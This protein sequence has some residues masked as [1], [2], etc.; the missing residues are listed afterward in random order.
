LTDDDAPGAK[1]VTKTGAVIGTPAYMSPEQLATSPGL[2][3]RTDL[4]SLGVVLFEMLSGFNPYQRAPDLPQ[5]LTWIC[6]GKPPLLTE[7]A[8]WV[9]VEV[10][11]V[12]QRALVQDPAHR[13]ASAAEMIAACKQLLTGPAEIADAMLVD[14]PADQRGAPVRTAAMPAPPSFA[15][16]PPAAPTTP[17]VPLAVMTSPAAPA[18]AVSA[19]GPAT[20]TGA[21]LPVRPP[22][23]QL[24][25]YAAGALV[26]LAGGVMLGLYVLPDPEPA[27][28]TADAG[29]SAASTPGTS[30]RLTP[31]APAVPANATP[32]VDAGVPADMDAGGAGDAAAPTD[33][34]ASAPHSAGAGRKPGTTPTKQGSSE[35]FGSG[36]K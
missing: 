19:L 24:L 15:G 12:V 31:V 2:D 36:N 28:P 27:Q 10:A 4:W 35:P 8:P 7:H 3:F 22:G 1:K 25:P 23:R 26:L 9:P 11:A 20:D 21:S 34:G 16:L 6:F 29:A 5:L 32:L 14:L 30:P 13:Y 33:A 18:L 17:A